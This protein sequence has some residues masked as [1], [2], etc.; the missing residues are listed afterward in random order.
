MV[1]VKAFI[2]ISMEY[3]APAIDMPCMGIEHQFPWEKHVFRILEREKRERTKK[4][5]INKPLV[6]TYRNTIHNHKNK[7]KKITQKV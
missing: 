7:N 3:Y 2:C 4:N 6:P 5:T 1:Q